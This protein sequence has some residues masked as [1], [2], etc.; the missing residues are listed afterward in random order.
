MLNLPPLLFVFAQ[1]SPV[2][3]SLNACIKVYEFFQDFYIGTHH[4]DVLLLNRRNSYDFTFQT[5]FLKTFYDIA[6]EY[7]RGN[8]A[9]YES[10]VPRVTKCSPGYGITDDEGRYVASRA[11]GV[12]C[13][14]CR[15]G[16]FSRYLLDSK[17]ETHTCELC[18]TGSYQGL[19]GETMCLP[20]EPGRVADVRGAAE[21][22]RC[23]PGTYADL[24]GMSECQPCGN[25]TA[26]TTSRVQQL[27]SGNR[28]VVVEGAD[29]YSFCRCAQDFFLHDAGCYPC[30]EGTDCPGSNQLELLPGFFSSTENPVLFSGAMAMN[31]GAQAAL[32]EAAL[33]GVTIAA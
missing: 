8:R 3:K 6:C 32:L 24:P 13:G 12:D 30:S 1:T 21:C 4:M 17:G 16:T 22:R 26:W 11:G 14:L 10:W 15:A 2:H 29:S 19:S 31:R 23:S 5:G 27:S 7:L 18:S 28:W 25:G 20:C 33:Q 9:L